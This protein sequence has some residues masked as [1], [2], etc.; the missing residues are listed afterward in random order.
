MIETL[1]LPG[2][3][4][5]WG[6]HPGKIRRRNEDAVGV[7]L[8]SGDWGVLIVLADGMGGHGG[9]EVASKIVCDQLLQAGNE[10]SPDRPWVERFDAL[11]AAFYEAEKSVKETAESNLQLL[12]MG[13]TAVAAAITPKTVLHLHVGDSRLYLWR[14]GKLL[15]RTR[16]HSVVEILRELGKIQESEM[17]Q[18]P[19]RN[20]LL[21]SLGGGDPKAQLDVSPK[22]R[23]GESEQDAELSLEPGDMVLLCTDGLNGMIGEESLANIIKLSWTSP[24][25][26]IAQLLI[27]AA[28]DAGGEDN[29]TV[30]VSTISAG[31]EE[32]TEAR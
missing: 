1:T 25:A 6:T 23:D 9:G 28:I 10:L 22:W 16:D 5:A 31:D 21:A 27:D 4:I 15:Y 2:I 26:K 17:R 24:P 7:R 19:N 20:M 3:D 12:G 11:L 30:A 14:D 8:L 18:H 29:V 32:K 13:S